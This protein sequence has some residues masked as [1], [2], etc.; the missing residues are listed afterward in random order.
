MT[1]VLGRGTFGLKY[2]YFSNSTAPLLDKLVFH[3]GSLMELGGEAVSSFLYAKKALAMHTTCY[4]KSTKVMGLKATNAFWNPRYYDPLRNTLTKQILYTS[5]LDLLDEVRSLVWLAIETR[6]SLI[7]PNILGHERTKTVDKYK[8]QAMW[9]GFRI[10]F[11]KRVGGRNKLKVEIL[12]PSY[13]WRIARDYDQPP[14]PHIIYYHPHRDDLTDIKRKVELAGKTYSR[15][16]LHADPRHAGRQGRRRSKTQIASSLKDDNTRYLNSSVELS[17]G[18]SSLSLAERQSL[19]K[20]EQKIIKVLEESIFLWANDSVGIFNAPYSQL[21]SSYSMI[22]SVKDIKDKGGASAQEVLQGMRTCAAIF[23]AHK[24]NR[25][26][27]Q[28]C[29]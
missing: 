22:P 29:D 20:E 9:P 21:I 5:D 24:G 23:G 12:E 10:A 16:V 11:L 17:I 1:F 2:A 18:S 3:Q 26:C 13:Y 28:I 14:Q 8:N 19:S 4:E 6:R 7:I 27:F 15:I 25:T